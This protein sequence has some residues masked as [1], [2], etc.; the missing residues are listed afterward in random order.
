MR[1]LRQQQDELEHDA[2]RDHRD[3]L[4]VADA[5]PEDAQ[6][7]KRGDGKVPRKPE[8]R[9]QHFLH[10]RDLA[11][12]CSERKGDCHGQH[13]GGYDPERA[14]NQMVEDE[15]ARGENDKAWQKRLPVSE[16]TL[17]RRVRHG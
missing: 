4:R 16:G 6:G 14:W 1:C 12:Y 3:L 10:R 8:E 2:D 11:T 17:S 15:F 7:Y 5:E 9:M 13:E